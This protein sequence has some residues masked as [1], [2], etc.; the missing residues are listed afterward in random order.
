MDKL[1][2]LAELGYLAAARR[3]EEGLTQ[4]ALA[5]LAGVGHVTVVRLEKGEGALRLKNAWTILETLGLVATGGIVTVEKDGRRYSAAYGVSDGIVSVRAK[6]GEK[7]TQ[8][9][10]SV[11]N[12]ESLARLLLH[13][14]INEAKV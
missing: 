13:E 3:R 5:D 1:P 6:G 14:L 2:A 12:E 7:V 11:G 8:V 9:G 4:K 10:G